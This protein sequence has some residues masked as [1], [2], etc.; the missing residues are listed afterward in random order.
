MG[1]KQEFF[2]SSKQEIT[3][4]D[5]LRVVGSNDV[6][7]KNL[8]G[9]VAKFI[10]ESYIASLAGANQSVQE[11][12]VGLTDNAYLGQG[13]GTCSTSASTAAKVVTLDNYKL[14]KGGIVA[15]KFTYAV[16]A[17]ATMNINSTGAKPIRYNGNAIDSQMIRAND[18]AYFIYDGA[19]YNLLFASASIITCR[20][21]YDLRAIS[22]VSSTTPKLYDVIYSVAD[23]LGDAEDRVDANVRGGSVTLDAYTASDY[24]FPSDGYLSVTMGASATARASVSLF[25]SQRNYI[26][27]MGALSNGD[28]PSYLLFVKKGMKTRVTVSNSGHVYFYPIGA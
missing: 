6:S 7:Y 9:D 17:S 24:T 19:N 4:V 28:Y 23:R 16:P 22:G 15:V 27:E 2:L 11:A 25:D 1:T 5:Y 14:I 12:L 21:L 18:T 20:E 26:G 8:V 13:S 10:I 3:S